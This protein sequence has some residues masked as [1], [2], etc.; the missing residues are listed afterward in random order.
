MRPFL[1]VAMALHA[2]TSVG[3]DSPPPESSQ[4]PASQVAV[5]PPPPGSPVSPPGIDPT[6]SPTNAAE[7]PAVTGSA[8][9]TFLAAFR[10]AHTRHDPEAIAALYCWDGVGA[11][12]GEVVM[13]NIRD[14]ALQ[15]VSEAHLVQAQPGEHGIEVSDGKRYVPNLD[16]THTLK[17]KYAPIA[18]APG[19]LILSEA[20]FSVGMKRGRYLCIVNAPQ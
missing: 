10:D 14:E 12:W 1:L 8:A 15:E 4:P 6:A 20:T 11:E 17:V 2:F 18:H 13:G 3:C 16:P 7:L 5:P 19:E 9:E